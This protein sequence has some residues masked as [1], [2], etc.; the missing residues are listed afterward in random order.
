M[1]L[2]SE[3]AAAVWCGRPHQGRHREQARSQ[4]GRLAL[5][6]GTAAFIEIVVQDG[7]DGLVAGFFVVLDH[8]DLLPVADVVVVVVVD[9]LLLLHGCRCHRDRGSGLLLL[10]E[11]LGLAPFGTPVLEP[12]LERGGKTYRF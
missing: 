8:I 9:L 2:A 1:Q 6:L 10:L 12:D 7:L 3:D 11:P 5:D 4:R